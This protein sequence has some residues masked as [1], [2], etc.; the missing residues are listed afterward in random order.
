MADSDD[1]DSIVVFP[2]VSATSLAILAQSGGVEVAEPLFGEPGEVLP[3][4]PFLGQRC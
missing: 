1:T 2:A 3:A 4:A